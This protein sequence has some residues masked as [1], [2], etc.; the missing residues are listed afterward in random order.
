MVLVFRQRVF[1]LLILTLFLSLLLVGCTLPLPQSRQ[2]EGTPTAV[3]DESAETD[4]DTDA[5]VDEDAILDQDSDAVE[6]DIDEG[7]ETAEGSVTE[8]DEDAEAPEA[9]ESDTPRPEEPEEEATPV[10]EDD[11]EEN[12]DADSDTDTDADAHTDT[13]DADEAEESAETDEEGEHTDDVSEAT[14]ETAVDEMVEETEAPTAETTNAEASVSQTHTVAPGEN[15]YRIG[16][17]YGVSWITLAEHNGL[18]NPSDIKVG[19]VLKIPPAD[20]SGVSAAPNPEPTPSPLTETTYVVQPGDNLF[21]IGLKFGM[22]W[23]PIAEANGIVNPNHIVVGQVLKIPVDAPGRPPSFTHIVKS[24]ETLFKI[25]L[26]YGVPWMSIA[27]AN[28][29]TSPYVIYPGQTL[30]IPGG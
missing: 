18:Q 2:P 9:E 24:G 23:V 3:A 7:A 29:L 4:A 21:R 19:Q 15:L 14:G 8:M 1:I 22:S 16:L 17:Q 20:G 13:D 11:D 6:E 27:E 5:S 10:P 12:G 30:V 28:N 26:Q 25:A